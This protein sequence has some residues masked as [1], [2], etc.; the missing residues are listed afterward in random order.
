MRKVKF[1][2][3]CHILENAPANDVIWSA[4]YLF[5][6]VNKSQLKPLV[7]ALLKNPVCKV[8]VHNNKTGVELP[9]GLV[10][11]TEVF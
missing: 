9:N 2:S 6:D 1:S 8:V 7:E 4:G 3:F 10:I 11:F 5:L